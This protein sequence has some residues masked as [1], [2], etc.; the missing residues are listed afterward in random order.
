MSNLDAALREPWVRYDEQLRAAQFGMWIFIASEVLFFGAFFCGFTYLHVM[1]GTA[2]ALASRHTG[3]PYG[4]ANTLI[5]LTSSLTMTIASRAARGDFRRLTLIF[6]GLTLA[7]GC[8]FLVVKGFEY[9][10][11]FDRHLWPGPDFALPLAATR[12]FFAGYWIITVIHVLHLSSGIG[13]VGRLTW[14]LHRG[15]L[16]LASPQ[17]DVTALYWT[18]VDIVWVLLFPIIYLGGRS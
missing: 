13:L 17:M 6:L 2:F 15:R 12:L 9:K 18:L 1:H 8:A 14:C 16:P 4:L 7:L 5:L 3:L 11:D 10:D